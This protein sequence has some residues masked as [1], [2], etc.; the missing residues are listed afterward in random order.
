MIPENK[1]KK[2]FVTT[3]RTRI[4]PVIVGVIM[5]SWFFLIALSSD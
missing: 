4:L 1:E 5:V 2:D 3:F